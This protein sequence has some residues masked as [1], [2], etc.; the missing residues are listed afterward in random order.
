MTWLA[1]LVVIA[2]VGLILAPLI[3]ICIRICTKIIG[4]KSF[5]K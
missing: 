5:L 2:I 1:K 4:G 3:A